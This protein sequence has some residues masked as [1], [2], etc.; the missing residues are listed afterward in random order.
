MAH[1]RFEAETLKAAADLSAK[2]YFAVELT[3][4]EWECNLCNAATDIPFGLLQ[5]KPKINE[6]GTVAVRGVSK[7]VVDGNA[8]AIAIGDWLGTDANG[9]LVK[10]S[11]D[12]AVVLARAMQAA[13]VDGAIITVYLPGGPFTLSV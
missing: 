10:K 8:G 5:N 11:A 12:K 9:K 2:Q 3:A 4:N 13:T 6:A 1:E 7:A